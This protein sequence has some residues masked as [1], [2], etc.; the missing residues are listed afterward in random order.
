MV[1]A[2]VVVALGD[3][4]QT[5][6]IGV[7]VLLAWGGLALAAAWVWRDAK[8]LPS[9]LL[10][11]AVALRVVLLFSPATLSDDVFR[12][13][14][15]GRVQLAGLDPFLFAP[16]DP[17]LSEL[18]N[19]TWE[20]V[21]HRSV[22]TIYP[23]G[24]QLFFRVGA[25]IHEGPLTWKLLSGAADVG[26]VW[27]LGKA[28]QAR[29]VPVWGAVLWALHPLPIVESAGSGHLEGLALFALAATL[30]QAS[31]QRA[32]RAAVWA[33]LGGLIK[34]LPALA[35]LPLLRQDA[36]RALGGIGVAAGVGVILSVPFWDAG[37]TLLRGFGTYYDAWAFNGLLYPAID[38]LAP[39]HGRTVA[40]GLGAIWCGVWAWRARDPAAWMLAVSAALILLSPVVH[41][42]YLLWPLLPAMVLGRWEWAALATVGALPYLVLV[43]YDPGVPDSWQE[44]P[45]V[46]IV[47]LLVLVGSWSVVQWR[48]RSSTP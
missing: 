32:G 26:T 31:D 4:R 13:L 30:W 12:Y 3:L 42:W 8:A 35:W 44:A 28:A 17:T 36:K 7:P 5:A 34:V 27:A 9:A 29:R 22:S 33:G 18:R 48:R 24:A 40:V 46:P 39:E 37:P 6:H 20:Q 1:A 14:W 16:D 15:E 25:W 43:G 23:P 21:N 47:E 38:A 19:G 41:P 11:V 10:A 2:V 45:W